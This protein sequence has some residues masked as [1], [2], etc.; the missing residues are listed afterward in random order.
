MN[1][2]A[3][4]ISRAV[5]AFVACVVLVCLVIQITLLLTGGADAN[6]GESGTAVSEGTRLVRLFS[7]FTIQSNIVVGVVAALL[8]IRPLRGSLRWQVARMDALLGIVITGLVF[9]LVLARQVDLHGWA[10]VAT[11]GFHYVT[12]WVTLIAWIVLGPRY[13]FRA[14]TVLL[15]FAWPILWLVYTFVRGAIVDWYPYPF[16]D[17]NEKGFGVALGNSLMVVVIAVVLAVA[18]VQIDRRVP[19][20]LGDAEQPVQPS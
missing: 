15:A 18:F 16:L 11:I 5:H 8:A 14:R 17:V 20:R 19:A 4:T 10:L 9:D 2:R 6:S 7:F 12:P 3:A 13:R 1:P